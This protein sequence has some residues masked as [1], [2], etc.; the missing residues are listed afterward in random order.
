MMVGSSYPAWVGIFVALL[1]GGVVRLLRFPIPAP[2][3][4]TG[5]L[6]VLAMTIGYL[7]TNWL[8]Q[9]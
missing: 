7:L 8:L 4:I 5:A 2:P 6:M 9:R 3:T 1:I